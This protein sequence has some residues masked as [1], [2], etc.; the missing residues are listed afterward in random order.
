MIS[1]DI[2]GHVRLEIAHLG[3]DYNGTLAVDGVLLQN[4]GASTATL[5]QA[6][7]VCTGILDALDLLREPRRL[8]ATLRS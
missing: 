3:L 6:D 4:E 5:L 2:P 8:I 1:I 7:V